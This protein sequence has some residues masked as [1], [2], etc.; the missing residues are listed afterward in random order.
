[1]TELDLSLI[2]DAGHQQQTAAG[3][4]ELAEIPTSDLVDAFILLKGEGHGDLGIIGTLQ[5]VLRDIEQTITEREGWV[6]A[7]GR[8]DGKWMHLDGIKLE[9]SRTGTWHLETQ[10][11]AWALIDTITTSLPV[12]A[13]NAVMFVLGHMGSNDERWSTTKVRETLGLERPKRG[14]D[15]DLEDYGYRDEGRYTIRVHPA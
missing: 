5:T 3:A 4:L 11:V 15:D 13:K 6:D 1:M 14:E 7:R 8:P 9:R 2:L 12:E 10:Q